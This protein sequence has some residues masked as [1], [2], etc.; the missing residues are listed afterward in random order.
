MISF[1]VIGKW[2]SK[3]KI[4]SWSPAS[5]HTVE[6]SFLLQN[7]TIRLLVDVICKIACI[8]WFWLVCFCKHWNHFYFLM[9]VDFSTVCLSH[10]LAAWSSPFFAKHSRITTNFCSASNP[11]ILC[12]NQFFCTCIATCQVSF[13]W[14]WL[15]QDRI[16]MD[17]SF[18]NLN[19][20]RTMKKFFYISELSIPK[21]FQN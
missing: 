18:Q 21:A 16:E 12:K 13:Q 2:S 7:T 8:I 10:K 20:L 9:N 1:L 14:Q 17:G 5:I 19:Y 6:N 15:W 3:L 4:R 11:S